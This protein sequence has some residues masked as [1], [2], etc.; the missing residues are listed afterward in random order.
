[1][2]SPE[3]GTATSAPTSTGAT[4]TSSSPRSE[5]LRRAEVDPDARL[6]E[7]VDV[8]PALPTR[9]AGRRHRH[10]L[11]A[12]RQLHRPHVAATA[13]PLLIVAAAH[14]VLARRRRRDRAASSVA[15]GPRYPE[16]SDRPPNVKSRRAVR[17]ARLGDGGWNPIVERLDR[18]RR[19]GGRHR[20]AGRAARRDRRSAQTVAV[21][22]AADLDLSGAVAAPR[23]PHRAPSPSRSAGSASCRSTARSSTAIRTGAASPTRRTRRTR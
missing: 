8:S 14:D 22:H 9:I 2:R 17:S 1:M 10:R 5:P 20:H 11:R 12:V 18:R 13:R 16:R 4:T 3:R 6:G 23:R 21:E 19:S 7:P 15:I